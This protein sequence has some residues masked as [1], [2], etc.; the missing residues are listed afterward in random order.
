MYICIHTQIRIYR[1][2][3]HLD[4]SPLKRAVYACIH[5]NIYIHTYVY[6]YIHIYI[7]IYVHK[8]I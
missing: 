8:Y 7:C 5:I 6:I 3:M 1:V 4:Q 2:H